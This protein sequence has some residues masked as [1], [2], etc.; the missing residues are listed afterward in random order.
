[1]VDH[2]SIYKR[3]RPVTDFPLDRNY[4][5]ALTYVA[6]H[7]RR[8]DSYREE[9]GELISREGRTRRF[10]RARRV[11]EKALRARIREEKRKE[12]W[13]EAR[14]QWVRGELREGWG[15]TRA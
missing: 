2:Y 15:I 12:R 11:V 5:R 3:I 14:E 7:A 9:K 8:R 6:C 1:M 10:T 4:N 13:L